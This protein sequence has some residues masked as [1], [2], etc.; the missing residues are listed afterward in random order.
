MVLY[1]TTLLLHLYGQWTRCSCERWGLTPSPVTTV[2]ARRKATSCRAPGQTGPPPDTSPPHT[3]TLGARAS[4]F[5]GAPAR[6]VTTGTAHDGPP[7]LRGPPPPKPN[8]RRHSL[9]LSGGLAPLPPAGDLTAVTRER[10]CLSGSHS[11]GSLGRGARGRTCGR[12]RVDG[13][14]R[15]LLRVRTAA[16]CVFGPVA[17]AAASRRFASALCVGLGFAQS[18][19]AHFFYKKISGAHFFRLFSLRS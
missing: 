16:M 9:S 13:P 6:A 7:A 1:T 15:R 18:S 14:M 2:T 12:R 5:P 8:G 19:W 4:F 10:S 3:H 11:A 17:L